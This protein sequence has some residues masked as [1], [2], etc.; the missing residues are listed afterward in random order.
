VHDVQGIGG[1]I[2]ALYDA[3]LNRVP[4]PLGFEAWVAASEHGMSL[5]DIAA[6][7]LGSAEVQSRFGGTTNAQFVEQLYESALHRSADSGGLQGWT[8]LLDNGVSRADVASG[9]SLSPENILGMQASLN[10]GVFVPDPD[11]RRMSRVFTMDCLGAR[12][13]LTVFPAGP[14]W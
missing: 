5:H 1:E 10:A 6:S 13:T 3:I 4:D 14:I 7:F 2:Y 11:A 9:I 8:N 12:R